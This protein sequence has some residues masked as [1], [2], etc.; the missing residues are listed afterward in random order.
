MLFFT[1][2]LVQTAAVLL[3]RSDGA[4]CSP[5]S[6]GGVAG[7]GQ[8]LNDLR[9]LPRASIFDHIQGVVLEDGLGGRFRYFNLRLLSL[10]SFTGLIDWTN[11]NEL[12]QLI[13]RWTLP[14]L[15]VFPN[16]A[17]LPPK[18]R[19]STLPCRWT[20]YRFLSCWPQSAFRQLKETML[21][22]PQAPL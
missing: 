9:G 8:V 18:A 6:P 19:L 21:D 12:L 4:A 11:L 20:S 7:L 10:D 15:Q 13:N 16:E 1:H 14:L 2:L 22:S 3:T 17:S 5:S